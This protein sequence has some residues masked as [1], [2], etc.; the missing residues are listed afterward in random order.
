[1]QPFSQFVETVNSKY[2][3]GTLP[4]LYVNDLENFEY[5]GQAGFS[6]WKN[7]SEDTFKSGHEH[8]DLTIKKIESRIR[9]LKDG[10]ELAS[11]QSFNT[12]GRYSKISDRPDLELYALYY[13]LYKLYAL[14]KGVPQQ[15][16]GK[17][18]PLLD[19]ASNRIENFEKCFEGNNTLHFVSVLDGIGDLVHFCDWFD[20]Y[21]K[22]KGGNSNTH[23]VIGHCSEEEKV[24]SFIDQLPANHY[25]K[26]HP[27][28]II[29][30]NYQADNFMKG[31][32]FRP[33]ITRQL[34][35][36]LRA[37]YII[38]EHT[39]TWDHYELPRIGLSSCAIYETGVLHKR[40]GYPRLSSYSFGI[41]TENY[42]TSNTIC[43]IG[44]IF[45]DIKNCENLD[46]ILHKLSD[47]MKL[48]LFGPQ[49]DEMTTEIFKKILDETTI[50]SGYY[51]DGRDYN[52]VERIVKKK[53]AQKQKILLV[54][55]GTE[56]IPE[57]ITELFPAF[58]RNNMEV[59]CGKFDGKDYQDLMQL[60]RT[61]VKH[62][63]FCSG[64]NTFKESFTIGKIPIFV[65]KQYAHSAKEKA[66]QSFASLL[67]KLSKDSNL[68]YECKKNIDELIDYTL[69]GNVPTTKALQLY[70]D[71]IA[72][73]LYENFNL[74]KRILYLCASVE[75]LI[76]ERFALN[77]QGF[78]Y[79]YRPENSRPML[80]SIQ[81]YSNPDTVPAFRM[82]KV[83]LRDE[84]YQMKPKVL[85]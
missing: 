14:K 17:A 84:Y 30:Q 24:I 19:W 4:A 75:G 27:D 44:F 53:I 81:H 63:F 55:T 45:P 11:E 67:S 10:S 41:G 26:D 42:E 82:E 3:N 34:E 25:L 65:F 50:I 32:I 18:T 78:S 64:D 23:V 73:Y 47:N 52:K 83:L 74:N 76:P 31:V 12:L 46:A 72:P 62:V 61:N 57:H 7:L 20:S 66:V 70:A 60:L 6:D 38:S 1:M 68:D 33:I 79:P 48:K 13:S 36:T 40:E 15:Y 56:N 71:H 5:N 16:N 58:L 49:F 85:I 2:T 29:C 8:I 21:C 22:A 69:N 39:L 28:L 54:L 35:K 43:N 80:F 51:Q 77:V 59:V 37:I 9:I